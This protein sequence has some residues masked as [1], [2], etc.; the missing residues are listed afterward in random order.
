MA[1]SLKLYYNNLWKDNHLAKWEMKSWSF[2][3]VFSKKSLWPFWWSDRK[4]LQGYSHWKE[5]SNPVKYLGN[6]RK[7]CEA[8]GM[9]RKGIAQGKSNIS[10]ISDFS[11][12]LVT[13]NTGL[14]P[15]GSTK[16]LVTDH[17]RTS[18]SRNVSS[19]IQHS[20]LGLPC[21]THQFHTS[22][23][24]AHVCLSWGSY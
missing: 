17:K 24:Y 10:K 23:R 20:V 4:K 2:N 1:F 8:T 7:V 3:K 19:Y 15:S 22:G 14:L 5:S 21:M 16:P 13:S 11:K 6:E 9:Y 18:C 12:T